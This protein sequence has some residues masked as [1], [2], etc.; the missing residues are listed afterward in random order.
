MQFLFKYATN[1]SN[2]LYFVDDSLSCETEIFSR[3]QATSEKNLNHFPKKFFSPFK[4][5]LNR[6][7]KNQRFFVSSFALGD[8][9]NLKLL[10]NARIQQ[11]LAIP[12][13]KKNPL[14]HLNVL[15]PVAFAQKIRP[16]QKKD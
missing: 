9:F 13:S 2:W 16:N 5:K 14:K 6:I 15:K 3:R 12:I 4:K 1:R 11:H 10:S 8:A 7:R